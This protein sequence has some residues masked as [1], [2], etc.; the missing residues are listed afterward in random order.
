M[1]MFLRRSEQRF[2]AGVN[3]RS[4]RTATFQPHSRDDKTKRTQFWPPGHDRIRF[5]SPP[6][7]PAAWAGRVAPTGRIF[8]M[9]DVRA[10]SLRAVGS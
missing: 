7:S 6:R 4:A 10:H 8:A 5:K 3:A 2:A 1:K 9:T